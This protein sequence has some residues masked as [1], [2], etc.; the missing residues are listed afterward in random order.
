MDCGGDQRAWALVAAAPDDDDPYF[1]QLI[2]HVLT[3]ADAEAFGRALA[4]MSVDAENLETFT[5]VQEAEQQR[6][7][8]ASATSSPT[9]STARDTSTTTDAP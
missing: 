1:V 4:S 7:A 6:A 2:A 8:A 9:A 5:E 3:T